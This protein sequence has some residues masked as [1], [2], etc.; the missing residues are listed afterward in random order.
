MNDFL[1]ENYDLPQGNFA[2]I[3]AGENRFRILSKPVI[4]WL[5]WDNEKKCHRFTNENKPAKPLGDSPVRHFWAMKVYNYG[6]KAVQILEITQKGLMSSIMACAKDP[7]W[8]SPLN[9]DIKITR[10]GDGKNTEYEFM[11]CPKKD[12]APEIKQFA[13]SVY[14]YLP[15]IFTGDDPF[16]VPSKDGL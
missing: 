7:D 14:C 8:G 9:F 16:V 2:K 11:P 5:D 13:D 3:E 4:G 15:S 1:P 10:K 6:S 12:L